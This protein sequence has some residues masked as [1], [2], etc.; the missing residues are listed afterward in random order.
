MNLK[1]KQD[2]RTLTHEQLSELRR[3]A[4]ASVQSGESPEDVARVFGV[5]RAS[6]YNWLAR[7]R[8][9]GWGSL[10]AKARGGR[11]P[12]VSGKALKWVYDLVT[13]KDPRQLKFQF[14][15]WTSKMIGLA[16]KEKFGIN[17]SKASVCRLLIQLGLTAQRPLWKAYQQ[18]PARVKHWLESEYPKIKRLA[19][20]SG[21][22]IFFADEAGLRSDHH[23]GT[24][25]GKK[26]QT[27]VVIGTGARFGFNV[28]S[29]VSAQGEFRFMVVEGTIG[30]HKFV[31]FMKRLIH[32][33]GEKPVYL[34]VDGHPSHKS[35]LAQRFLASDAVK[36]KLK[37]F[38]L[39]PY[40]PELNPDEHVWNDLKSNA[41]GRMS[42]SDKEEMK[43]AAVS[44]LRK[45][46]KRPERVASY[47]NNSTTRYAA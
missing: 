10:D 33:A 16:I 47:F 5:N 43:S 42:F 12:L 14:A 30:A 4:V 45:L 7:Y 25:W 28:I 3:R 37:L 32:G 27:P 40:S 2:A 22:S 13:L 36:D 15:L 1:T 35:K 24:T 34:I 41:M 44:F 8:S 38:F 20:K 21:A 17:L 29:A 23:A 26:G 6:V 9:G 31:E 39:P 11:K 18:D 46:Q 19:K